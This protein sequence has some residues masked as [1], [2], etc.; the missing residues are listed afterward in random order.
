MFAYKE[1]F[2]KESLAFYVNKIWIL[3]NYDNNTRDAN[4]TIVPN[5]FFNIAFISGQGAVAKFSR[6]VIRL[7]QGIHFCGQADSAVSVDILPHTRVNMVQL[8]PWTASMFINYNMKLCTNKI[9][10]FRNLNMDFENEAGKIDY[11]DETSVLNFIND[12]FYDFLT[13]TEHSALIRKSCATIMQNKGSISIR[14]LSSQLS[15]SPRHLQKLFLRYIGLSPKEY[16]I[17]IKLR[18]AI[19]GMVFPSSCFDTSLT[20]LALDNDFYDQA[21]FNNTFKTI[22]RTPPGKF[23]PAKCILAFRKKN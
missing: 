3:D 17:I 11:C 20:S 15:C 8:F 7:K 9:I 10:A 16:S 21:H 1:L 6:E 5:G 2:V 23:I 22:V 4:K 13:D 18:N 19:E 14:D 12:R